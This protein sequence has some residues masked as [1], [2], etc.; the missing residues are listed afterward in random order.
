[1]TVTAG[2]DTTGIDAALDTASRIAGRITDAGGN[3]IANAHVRA[4]YHNGSGW[5]PHAADYTDANGTYLLSGLP[6]AGHIVCVGDFDA[7]T[8]QPTDTGT[9]LPRCYENASDI[10]S[11]QAVVTTVGAETS[12]I[13]LAV[14]LR[15]T[16]GA[17][18]DGDS[19]PDDADNCPLF[20]NQNQADTD[21]DGVGDVCDNCPLVANPDQHDR[22]GDGIGDTCDP[23]TDS[24]ADGMPD[25][26]ELAHGFDPDDPADA[27][28]DA[29]GD[30][31]NNRDEYL[32][33]TDALEHPYGRPV[34][35]MYIAYY[36]RPGDP[37]G[38]NYWAGRMAAVGGNWI[39]DL[40]NAFGA[41]PEY[42][43]R[44]G[45]LS[46]EALIDNLYQQLFNRTADP[47]GR[48]FYID[49]LNASNLSGYNPTL[50]RSTL[51]QIA[52]DIANGT[53]GDDVLTLTNKL[54]VASDFTR[55]LLITA[56]GYQGQDIPLV[57]RLIATVTDDRQTVDIALG[58]VDDFMDGIADGAWHVGSEVLPGTYANLHDGD[59]AWARLAGFSGLPSD[60]LAN[61]W[62]EEPGSALVTIG[63]TDTGFESSNCGTWI[64]DDMPLVTGG[65]P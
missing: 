12:G 50:R 1:M 54:D 25:G 43:D 52:L 48:A 49:L 60:I 4:W 57:S 26:Y 35:Q 44:F 59:C 51:A 27:A 38:V 64:A 58:Y 17:D 55:E 46:D 36:G 16:G 23:D 62:Q 21:S 65:G 13:D 61:G 40:V 45:D 29:D 22:D 9:F 14:L 28:A 30:G 34:Q 19:V 53:T 42:T 15:S 37:G 31:V 5:G 33:R 47:V 32:A 6:A 20:F 3:P 41:S 7:D 8:G 56:H 24:D 18:G 63:A 2:A 39:P 11:A 10:G